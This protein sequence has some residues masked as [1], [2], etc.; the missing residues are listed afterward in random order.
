MLPL[1]SASLVLAFAAAFIIFKLSGRSS[2]QSTPSSSPSLMSKDYH[3]CLHCSRITIPWPSHPIDEWGY[4]S[5]L[6]ITL[7]QA[8]KA[9]ADGCELFRM[10]YK[11]GAIP[12]VDRSKVF[13][14]LLHTGQP[15]SFILGLNSVWQRWRYLLKGLGQKPIILH[16]RPVQMQRGG[17]EQPSALSCRFVVLDRWDPLVE[18]FAE[19]GTKATILRM[20]PDKSDRRPNVHLC[21]IFPNQSDR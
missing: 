14:S 3:S 16:F 9:A 18:V 19:K 13:R 15:I 10:L 17:L 20:A 12:A 7:S 4:N 11:D 6:N 5:P 2:T 8:R 21:D 1:Q